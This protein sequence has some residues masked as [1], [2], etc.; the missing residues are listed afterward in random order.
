MYNATGYIAELSWVMQCFQVQVNCNDAPQIKRVY[1][2]DLSKNDIAKGT[3]IKVQTVI[4][5]L[6]VNMSLFD[7]W[8]DR[9]S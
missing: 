5:L 2:Q 1:L 9:G 6:I 7:K 3:E 4:D 8:Q